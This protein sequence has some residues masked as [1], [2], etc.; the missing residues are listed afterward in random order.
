MGGEGG[1]VWVWGEMGGWGLRS[2][3]VGWDGWVYEDVGW[4]V[5]RLRCSPYLKCST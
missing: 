1:R 5:E 4:E 2:E 3:G